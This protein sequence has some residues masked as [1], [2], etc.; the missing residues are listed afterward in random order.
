MFCCTELAQINAQF[1][2]SMRTEADHSQY[3]NDNPNKGTDDM[4][5]AGRA[6]LTTLLTLDITSN[7]SWKCESDFVGSAKDASYGIV[8]GYMFT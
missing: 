3:G 4:Q 2:L 7:T 6:Y 5:C 1:G 8:V